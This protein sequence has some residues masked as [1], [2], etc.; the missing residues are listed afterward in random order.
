V[1]GGGP[2]GAATGGA[3]GATTRGD[4]GAGGISTLTSFELTSVSGGT[5]LPFTVGLGFKEGDVADEFVLDLESAQ[6]EVKRRWNDGSVKHAIVSG[7]VDLVAAQPKKIQILTGS[8]AGGKKLTCGDIQSAAPSA[9]VS[10]GALGSVDL[11]S[12]LSA[13]TR[14]WLSGSDAVECH[15]RGKV[16]ADATLRV[17]YHVRLYREGRIFVRAIVEN[18]FLDVLTPDKSYVPAVSID[19]KLVYDGGGQELT[20]YAHTRWFAEAWIG[21]DPQVIPRHDV[22]ALVRSLLVPNYEQKPAASAAL[23]GLY[24]V[25]QPYEHGG[26]TPHMGETGFQEQIGILPNWDALYVTSSGDVRALAASI[27]NTKALNSYPLVWRDSSDEGVVHPSG[28][29]TWTV[30]GEQGG[31][32]TTSGAGPLVWDNAHHGSGGY[33]A[34]LLTGDYLFL[35]TMEMQS[36]LAYL[37]VSSSSGSG[38]G[39]ILT[40]QTRAMAWAHRT[41][42]QYAAIAPL[43][44]TSEDYRALLASNAAH[45]K[46]VVSGLSDKHLGLVYSYELGSNAY[47]DGLIAPWQQNFMAQV[48]GHISDLEPLANMDDW[49]AVRDYAY[50]FPVGLLG[51]GGSDGYC[52]TQASQYTLKVADAASDDLGSTYPSWAMVYAAI[53]DG[54]PC[55]NVLQG[56]S[57]GAPEAAATGYYGNLLPAIAYAVDHHAPG[58]SEAWARLTGAMNYDAVKNSEF[59]KVAVWGVAPR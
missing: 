29:P 26:W 21:G 57:G 56:S 33:L 54:A 22:P 13:P 11:S 52:F 58:A 3:G 45:W 37:L 10:L 14:T 43:T 53:F 47:G 7:H 41:V 30:N 38:P 4:A 24:Q 32:D 20:H 9:T 16:G 46:G 44:P 49:N 50:Q 35:E 1:I 17:E 36:S 6:V 39:R 27:A 28:R 31:G 34:Y 55:G 15:Y 40:G 12:L 59:D 23:D 48:F 18:G 8:Y 25:Y 51:T 2:V 19:G 42:G 5:K